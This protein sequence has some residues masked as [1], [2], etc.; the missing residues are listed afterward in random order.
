MFPKMRKK[1]NKKSFISSPQ[2]GLHPSVLSNKNG[3]GNNLGGG[4]SILEKIEEEMHT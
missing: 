3:N 2:K 1:K 4:V